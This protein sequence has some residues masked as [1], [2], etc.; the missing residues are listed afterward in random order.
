MCKAVDDMLMESY[1]KGYAI[2]YKIGLELGYEMYLKRFELDILADLVK[3][4]KICVKDA[5]AR[6]G[7]TEDTFKKAMQENAG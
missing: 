3:D 2:G 4:N 5:A 6:L 1:N 7:M